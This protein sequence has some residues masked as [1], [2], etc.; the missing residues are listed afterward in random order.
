MTFG[1]YFSLTISEKDDF[2]FYIPKGFAQFSM[3]IKV[4]CTINYKCSDYRNPKS[5]TTLKFEMKKN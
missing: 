3:F 4:S 1:K 2:S 5:E